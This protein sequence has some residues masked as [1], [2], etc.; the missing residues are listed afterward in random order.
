MTDVHF[1]QYRYIEVAVRPPRTASILRS[2]LGASRP[3]PEGQGATSTLEDH[4]LEGPINGQGFLPYVQKVL[5]PTLMPGDIVIRDSLGSHGGRN[6]LR[7]AQ[8]LAA[9]CRSAFRRCDL[10]ANSDEVGRAN[11]ATCQPTQDMSRSKAI[12]L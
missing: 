9:K 2:W 4:D 12:T 1:P 3:A 11:A 5:V 7:Q 10:H 6:V 8:G